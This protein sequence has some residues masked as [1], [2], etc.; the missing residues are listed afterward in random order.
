MNWAASCPLASA[1][2]VVFGPGWAFLFGECSYLRP[3]ACRNAQKRCDAG[4]AEAAVAVA[5]AVAVEDGPLVFV[6]GA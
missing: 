6:T 4:E 1:G 5:V 2:G 3:G